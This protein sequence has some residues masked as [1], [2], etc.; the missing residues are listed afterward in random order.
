MNNF[1]ELHLV[2]PK[3]RPLQI[4]KSNM[5]LFPDEKLE[6]P[7]KML[8]CISCGINHTVSPIAVNGYC[9]DC[10]EIYNYNNL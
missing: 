8:N 2:E 7:S 4:L 9:K 5:D 3:I 6:M 10:N 1:I